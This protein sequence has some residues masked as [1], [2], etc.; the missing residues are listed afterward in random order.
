MLAEVISHQPAQGWMISLTGLTAWATMYQPVVSAD[1][2][3][4]QC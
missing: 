3:T 1:N 2:H 4:W